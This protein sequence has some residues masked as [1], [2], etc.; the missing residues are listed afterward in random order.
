MVATL[1][2]GDGVD[3]AGYDATAGD[4]NLQTEAGSRNMGLDPTTHRVFVV[5]ATFGPAPGAAT[6]ENPRRRPPVLPGSF[7]MMVIENRRR[8]K[9]SPGT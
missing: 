6:A 8:K 5:G 3:G 2:I 7:M 4:E 9:M 1:P